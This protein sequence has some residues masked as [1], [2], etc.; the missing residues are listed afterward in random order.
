LLTVI[1]FHEDIGENIDMLIIYLFFNAYAHGCQYL[2]MFP[3]FLGLGGCL[4]LVS[5]DKNVDSST[6]SQF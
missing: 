3:D 6:Y 1:D 4:T 5:I 2:L